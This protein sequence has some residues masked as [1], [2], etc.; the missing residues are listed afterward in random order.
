MTDARRRQYGTRHC[1]WLPC[2]QQS[3]SIALP[4]LRQLA[5]VEADVISVCVKLLVLSV[6]ADLYAALRERRG[7]WLRIYAGWRMQNK[8]TAAI[9]VSYISYLS[10]QWVTGKDIKQSLYP[11]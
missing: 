2:M 1:I 5:N 3:T 6:M 9:N 7:H 4:F 11:P 8:K 10:I